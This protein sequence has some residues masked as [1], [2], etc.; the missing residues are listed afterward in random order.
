MTVVDIDTAVFNSVYVPHLDYNARVQIMYGGSSSGKSVFKARKTI[1]QVLQGGRNFLVCRA[2]ARTIRRSVFT[3]IMKNIHAWGLSHLFDDN[4]S[5]MMITCVNGY[6]ILF[7]GLDDVEKLKSI[8]PQVGVIT[9][10][11]CLLY[12]SPSPRDGLLS[13]MPSSA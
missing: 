10:I 12:T 6:Q 9:D 3:E 2:V 5:E 13:R 7:A 11:C 4:K 1:I 8:T